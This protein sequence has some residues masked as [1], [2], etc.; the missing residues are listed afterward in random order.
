MVGAPALDQRYGAGELRALARAQCLC[1]PRDVRFGSVGS[2]GHCV[3]NSG[4][5]LGVSLSS[6][7]NGSSFQSPRGRRRASIDARG[8]LLEQI[9]VALQLGG[10][11][12]DALGIVVAVLVALLER[13]ARIFL[14]LAL[15]LRLGERNQRALEITQLTGRASFRRAHVPARRGA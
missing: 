1:E 11:R 3:T 2:R 8:I 12:L 5:S 9:A 6:V 7:R 4:T 15:G 10:C 14:G 13:E